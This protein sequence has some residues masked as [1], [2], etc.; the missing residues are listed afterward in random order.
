MDQ[1]KAFEALGLPLPHIAPAAAG[2]AAPVLP[3]SWQCTAVLHPFSPPPANDPRPD[4]PFFQL[5]IA[6][7]GYVAGQVMSIQVT[8]EDQ[9][10]WWYKITPQGTTLSTDRGVSFHA[11]DTGW[12]LPTTQWTTSDATFF[13]SSYLNWMQAQMLDWWHQP[14]PDSRA[15]TWFWF[16]SASGGN[17][18]PFRL[19]F[20]GPPPTPRTGHPDQLAFFQNFSFTYFPDFA[21]MSNPPSIGTWTPPELPGFVFGNAAGMKLVVWNTNFAMTTLMTPVDS[22]SFPLPTWVVYHWASDSTYAQASDR[23]QNTTMSYDLNPQSPT[24]LQEALLFGPAPKGVTPPP[25]AD[26]AYLYTLQKDQTEQCE[27]MP[28]PAEPPDW[29]RIPA[30]LGT[31]HAVVTNSQALCPNQT[32]A[33]ISVL[34]PPGNNIYPQ[35]RFL[36][37]WYSPFP[38]SDGTRAR[39]VTFMESA[40]T[41]EEGGTSLALADYFAYQEF[42]DPISPVFFTIPAPCLAGTGGSG[43]D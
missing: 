18:L 42:P 39:P 13:G 24:A 30:A 38:G 12:T 3:T 28:F 10:T 5:C 41:I 27:P 26:S 37:T 29:A 32:V 20:G 14:V 1:T 8:G 43:G 2:A 15:A 7:I 31:I 19:M 16:N 21:A 23:A 35:G 4:I 25:H 40:S 6:T 9:R 11:V 36:W 33:I 17:G 34:F 22:K